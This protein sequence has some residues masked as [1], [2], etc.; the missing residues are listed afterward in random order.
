MTTPPQR[1]ASSRW[2]PALAGAAAGAAALAASELVAGLSGAPPLIV[3]V[4]ALAIDLQPP[5]A[6]DVVV[7]LFGTNDKPAL[8]ALVIAVA[9]ALA[10]V[11]GILAA[12][13]FS[14]GAAVFLVFGVVAAGA[15]I[16]SPLVEPALAV[17]NA[18]IAVGAGLVSLHFLLHRLGARPTAS[19]PLG[20]ADAAVTDGDASGS[21][22]GIQGPAPEAA[23]PEWT[24]RRFLIA[25]AGTIG[26]AAAAGGIGR[27]L[28]DAN[29]VEGVVSTSSLPRPLVAVPP[30]APD[31]VLTMPGLTP[32]V[33]PNDAFYRIDTALLVPHVDV[34]DLAAEGHG[35]GR[36]ASSRS[37][38]TSCSRCPFT[39]ST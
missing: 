29:H 3:A 10:A 15:A 38:M 37:P 31:Q 26:V 32:L 16:R 7:S 20:Q 24:R 9:I 5:G 33:V 34:A 30:L 21:T 25:S 18:A 12:R 8:I 35:H 4:G 23:S 27:S 22:H 28:I 39:S 13:R 2:A 19:V 1:A 17:V 11:A 14:L 6:K 36:P